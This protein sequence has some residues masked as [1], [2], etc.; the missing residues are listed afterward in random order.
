MSKQYSDEV[1]IF[2]A[3]FSRVF[4]I[5]LKHTIFKSSESQFLN[6]EN[7]SQTT[8]HMEI[9]Y[10][11]RSSQLLKSSTSTWKKC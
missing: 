10:I 5:F 9:T 11:K 8:P 2:I 7:A 6:T 3:V 4:G 1:Q